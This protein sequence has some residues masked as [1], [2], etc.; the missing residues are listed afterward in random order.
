MSQASAAVELSFP[1]FGSLRVLMWFET[2][3]S[4]LSIGPMFKDQPVLP[5]LLKMGP[6]DS[7][8]TS[9]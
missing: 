8:E 3:V 4:G 2:D 5:C 9:V 1:S 6:I 7:P